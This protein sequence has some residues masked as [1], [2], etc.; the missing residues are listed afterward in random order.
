MK[1]INAL[2]LVPSVLAA[3]AQADIL[4][5]FEAPTY[6]IGTL[7]GQSGGGVSWQKFEDG[8][9]AYVA[10]PGYNSAQSGRW[11][12]KD[13]GT[14]SDGD[15]MLGL[16]DSM[17]RLSVSA[18]SFLHL[19]PNRPNGT[20]RSGHFFVSDADFNGSAIAF[21]DSGNVGYW[22]GGGFYIN[23]TGVPLIYDQWVPIQIDM[24]YSTHMATFYYNGVEVASDS[25][26]SD[27]GTAADQMDIWL[28]TVAL[29]D[30]P[31]P[32]D[33][34][35]I[36]DIRIVVPAPASLAMLGLGMAGIVRRRR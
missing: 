36:D 19:E 11:D 26:T 17:S 30:N 25:M 28:D 33:W 23:D 10:M 35:Q 32:G 12:V 2:V 7:D 34:M 6:T 31:N 22:G 1:K 20:S 5:D 9:D 16:F 3:A 8:S 14:D 13:S 29:A 18:M 15:D 21:L 24:D 27:V 4:V